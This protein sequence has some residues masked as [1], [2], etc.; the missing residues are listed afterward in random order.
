MYNIIVIKYLSNEVDLDV[1]VRFDEVAEDLRPDVLQEVFDVLPD[2]RI[3]HDR[4]LVLLQDL[5]EIVD[6][7]LL[8][9]AV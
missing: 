3:L 5:L 6:V 1:G 4:L 9:R 2:E 7:V 8:V